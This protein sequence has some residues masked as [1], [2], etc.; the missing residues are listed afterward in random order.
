LHFANE[1]FSAKPR[2]TPALYAKFVGYL[3]LFYFGFAIEGI[4]AGTPAEGVF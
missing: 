3:I 1:P 4:F 2:E